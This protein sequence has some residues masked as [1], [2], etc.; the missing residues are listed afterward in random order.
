MI[1]RLCALLGVFPLVYAETG[2]RVDL[3]VAHRTPLGWHLKTLAGHTELL[4]DGTTK[5]LAFFT[6]GRW[7]EWPRNRKHLA[8]E[9][10]GEAA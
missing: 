9:R 1:K 5:N 6:V 10:D 4:P 8:W 3:W 7:K 2:G